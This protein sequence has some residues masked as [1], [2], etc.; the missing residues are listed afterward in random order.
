MEKRRQRRKRGKGTGRR[1][2]KWGKEK[3]R[4]KRIRVDREREG[5]RRVERGI[6]KNCANYLLPPPPFNSPPTLTQKKP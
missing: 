4:K 1:E 2:E 6:R 3:G 5:E